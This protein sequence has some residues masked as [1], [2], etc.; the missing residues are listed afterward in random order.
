MGGYLSVHFG[1]GFGEFAEILGLTWNDGDDVKKV[2]MVYLDVFVSYYKTARAPQAPAEAVEDSSLESYQW[3]VGKNGAPS[4]SQKGKE[5]IEHFGIKLEDEPAS[6]LEVNCIFLNNSSLSLV[7][8]IRFELI[9]KGQCPVCRSTKCGVEDLIPN[10]NEGSGIEGNNISYAVPV[11]KRNKGLFNYTSAEDQGSNLDKVEYAYT[12]QNG[13]APITTAAKSQDINQPLIMPQDYMPLQG[14]VPFGGSMI[15]V[16]PYSVPDY[17]PSLFNS[18]PVPGQ[19]SIDYENNVANKPPYE[20]LANRE[21]QPGSSSSRI[22]HETEKEQGGP[23]NLVGAESYF[24]VIGSKNKH[25][26]ALLAAS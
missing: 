5:K 22:H 12:L 13:K 2:Y 11:T 15:P 20:D 21:G 16:E 7:T 17:L 9:I 4:T 14:V 8:R 26:G 23:Q 1:Q 25:A 18:S 10:V 19:C 3:S 6:D 24:M